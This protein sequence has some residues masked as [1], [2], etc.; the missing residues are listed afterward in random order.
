MTEGTITLFFINKRDTPPQKKPTYIHVVCTNRPEKQ[1]PIASYGLLVVTKLNTLKKSPTKPTTLKQPNSYST[2]L[3]A[4]PTDTLLHWFWNTFSCE[5]TSQIMNTSL[6]PLICCLQP[7]LTSTTSNPRSPMDLFI[8]RWEKV[9]TDSHEHTMLPTTASSSSLI[10][11][12]MWPSPELVIGSLYN[13]VTF[14]KR[15]SC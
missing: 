6:S 3:L 8:L 12:D 15:D 14:F 5:V 11:L 4:L 9:C 7:S 1:N 13:H 2:M 10:L